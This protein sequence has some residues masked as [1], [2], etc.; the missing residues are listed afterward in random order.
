V[1]DDLADLPSAPVVLPLAHAEDGRAA[2]GLRRGAEGGRGLN[3]P[4][5]LTLR[6]EQRCLCARMPHAVDALYADAPEAHALVRGHAGPRR[7]VVK[8]LQ[9]LQPGV[10][11][12]LERGVERRIVQEP[13][14]SDL[15]GVAPDDVVDAG[16]GVVHVRL[17]LRVQLHRQ[18]QVAKTLRGAQYPGGFSADEIEVAVPVR[19]EGERFDGRGTVVEIREVTGDVGLEKTTRSAGEQPAR[20]E[21]LQRVE[22]SGCDAG[23]DA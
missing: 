9:E 13:G 17:D 20:G 4:I 15:R 6:L 10:R 11:A 2:I 1:V 3:H 8:R 12:R 23:R 7:M 21:A 5:D 14:G 19:P 22:F 16:R 18:G